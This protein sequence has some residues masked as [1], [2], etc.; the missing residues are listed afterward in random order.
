MSFDDTRTVITPEQVAV[1]YRLAGIGTRFAAMLVDTLI[2]IALA[3]VIIF[4]LFP[5]GELAIS[6]FVEQAE[7]WMVALLTLALFLALWGYFI[8]FEAVWSGRTPGK[9]LAGIRVMR[10]A[11]YPIDFRASFLRNICRY[12]DFLPLAYGV[13]AT[14]MFFS[15]DSKRLG[16]YVAGTIV[17]VDT[18]RQ[19]QQSE[20]K[21]TAAVE[22]KVLGDITVLNLRA[23]TRDQLA[24][25]DRYLERRETLLEGPRTELAHRIAE[26]LVVAVGLAAPSDDFPFEAFLEELAAACRQRSHG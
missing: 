23:V 2:Q 11:G 20:D 26:P 25:V 24:V 13:G 9:K 1:T 6:N 18:V 21:E 4:G 3:L 7:A 19:K 14:V 22:Y 15:K 8:F 5:G 10:D 12:I 16:D 17:V